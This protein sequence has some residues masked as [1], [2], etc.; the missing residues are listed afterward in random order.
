MSEN[1]KQGQLKTQRPTD[2]S[3]LKTTLGKLGGQDGNFSV[4]KG[5]KFR[6]MGMRPE[7][8]YRSI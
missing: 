2:V 4:K 8:P 7:G 6:D 1:Q 5:P 3:Q